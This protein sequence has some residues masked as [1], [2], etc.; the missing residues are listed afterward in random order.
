VTALPEPAASRPPGVDH[1]LTVAEYAELG[2]IEP[3]YTELVE[4]RLLM[5]PSP[6]PAH[7][8]ASKRLSYMLD[9]QLPKNLEVVQDVDIDLELVPADQPGYSRR[10]D[11]VVVDRTAIRRVGDAGGLLR[12]SDVH[13]VIEIVSPGSRRID[14]VDKRGEYADAGI[15][16]YWIVDISEPV[17]LVACHLAGEFG[18]QDHGAVT[19]EVSA[20][21]PF[22]LNL[23]LG[24]LR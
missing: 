6:R 1:L 11:L 9:T 16:Y 19:G 24:A 18:Y 8:I 12:A 17:S 20:A 13:L 7:N 14:N 10:P 3:G 4:G 5:S 2:E 22:P 21:E 15:A 23:D